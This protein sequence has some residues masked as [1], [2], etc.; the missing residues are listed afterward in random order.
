MYEMHPA[1]F[2]KTGCYRET[3][4]MLSALGY[5]TKEDWIIGRE[6]LT[7]PKKSHDSYFHHPSV[8]KEVGHELQ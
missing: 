5:K 2:F 3:I 6:T 4:G 8:Y 1:L 7:R